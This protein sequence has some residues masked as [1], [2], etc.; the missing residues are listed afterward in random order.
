MVA[1]SLITPGIAELVTN[2]ES[3]VPLPCT[4]FRIARDVTYIMHGCLIPTLVVV[5]RNNTASSKT[6]QS[7]RTLYKTSNDVTSGRKCSGDDSEAI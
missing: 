1:F 4:W 7:E 5:T 3:L 6:V 2:D